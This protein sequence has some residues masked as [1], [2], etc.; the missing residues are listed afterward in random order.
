MDLETIST[1]LRETLWLSLTLSAPV[2]AAALGTGLV[3]SVFQAATQVN[4]QTLTFVPK[5]V[6]TLLVFGLGFPH[7]MTTLA[8]FMRR[9]LAGGMVP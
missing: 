3:I 9:L 8:D 2:L 1:I 7:M 5:I 4:E 6:A